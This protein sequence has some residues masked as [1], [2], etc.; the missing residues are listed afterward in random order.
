MT[1]CDSLTVDRM[2]AGRRQMLKMHR[3]TIVTDLDANDIIDELYSQKVLT[4]EDIENI[5]AHVRN[6]LFL[7][8]FHAHTILDLTLSIFKKN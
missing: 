5:R 6:T 7:L 1:L 8:N 4:S 2:D 3:E